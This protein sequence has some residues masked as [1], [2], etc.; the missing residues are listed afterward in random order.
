M[1]VKAK[2]NPEIPTLD[3]Y[4]SSAPDSFWEKFPKN[5]LP[6]QVQTKINTE[7]LD[8][9][10]ERVKSKMLPHQFARAKK[11][12]NFLRYGAPA[13][14]K[15]SLP[16]CKV[17]NTHS[18]AE[19]G[20]DVADTIASW[21]KKGFASGFRVNCLMA[22]NQG[23]KVRPILNISLP[24]NCSFNDNVNEFELEKVKMC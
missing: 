4:S 7:V 6:S 21:V 1:F 11:A 5:D 20:A 12:L 24:E 18:T 8:E 9:K 10:I 15:I 23:S 19:Y 2:A 22:V 14:Q 3:S 17:S 16:G 13:Y